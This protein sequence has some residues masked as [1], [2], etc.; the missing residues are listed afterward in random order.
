MEG[1][2]GRYTEEGGS[3]LELE[4]IVAAQEARMD[5]FMERM[6]K[7]VQDGRP[8]MGLFSSSMMTV[9]LAALLPPAA[10][11]LLLSSIYFILD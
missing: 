3:L 6:L 1:E 9:S 7:R 10:L 5:A 11:I 2:D 4:K 8:G